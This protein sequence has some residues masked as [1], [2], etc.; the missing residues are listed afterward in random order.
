[1]WSQPHDASPASSAQLNKACS[2]RVMV[3]EMA[4][5]SSRA[6]V[7]TQWST[8]SIPVVKNYIVKHSKWVLNSSKNRS[9]SGRIELQESVLVVETDE[10]IKLAY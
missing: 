9:H 1:M 6:M 2:H 8:Y 10:V 5:C 7:A 4:A 3:K